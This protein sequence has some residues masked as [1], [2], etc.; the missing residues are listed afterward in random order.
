ML[1]NVPLENVS[2][3]WKRHHRRQRA[4]KLS[5]LWVRVKMIFEPGG[6]FIVPNLLCH[7]ALGSAVL[8]EGPAHF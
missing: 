8:F 5:H 1:F 6:I 7:E 4:A 3:I 2:F